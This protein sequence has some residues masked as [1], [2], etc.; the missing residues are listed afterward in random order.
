MQ[1]AD[2]Y[3]DDDALS[4][5]S[6][7]ET[8]QQMIEKY[9][10]GVSLHDDGCEYDRRRSFLEC[11]DIGAAARVL[12]QTLDLW[13]Q[14][15]W[16]AAPDLDWAALPETLGSAAPGLDWA[17]LD[18]A[19]RMLRANVGDCEKAVAMFLRALEVRQR[20]F[21]IFN[22]KECEPLC[23]IRVFARD[24]E[25]HP[26]VYLCTKS[27]KVPLHMLREQFILTFEK[28]CRLTPEDGQ[29][30]ALCDAHGMS[31]QLNTSVTAIK[32]FAELFGTV[33][34]ARLKRLVIIDFSRTA[35]AVWYMAQPLLT[36]TTKKKVFFV[37]KV[38]ALELCRSDFS[39]ADF[40]KLKQTLEINR[41]RKCSQEE[42]E[43]HAAATTLNE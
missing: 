42:R 23:D 19:E 16:Q 17:T 21:E 3:P 26:V 40:E 36:E 32:Y 35:Q 31:V 30:V 20:D 39:E 9:G 14:R 38:E 11:G 29:L 27:Q 43:R 28:A 13:Q 41:D 15:M 8:E 33:Y 25:C 4:F 12:E 7:L 37:G 18:T 10:L 5:C 22:G 34:A 1:Q 24:V 6:C 2:P